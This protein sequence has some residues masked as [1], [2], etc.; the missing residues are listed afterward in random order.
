MFRLMHWRRESDQQRQ[1][2][3]G[4]SATAAYVRA[5]QLVGLDPSL[6]FGG[7]DERTPV[8]TFSIRGQTLFDALQTERRIHALVEMENPRYFGLVM[9]RWES[10]VRAGIA[11]H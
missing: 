10:G 4:E 7:N 1:Q 6:S 9:F 11:S 2:E 8:L 5:A 3:F